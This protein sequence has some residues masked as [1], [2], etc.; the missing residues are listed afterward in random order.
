[1]IRRIGLAACA[2]VLLAVTG[3][4]AQQVITGTVVRMDPAAG[5][6]ALDNGQMYRATPQT[7]FLV[8]NQPTNFSMISP[9]T[10]VIVQSAQPVYYQDGRYI[11]MTQ[12]APAGTVVAAPAPVANAYE[13]SGVVKYADAT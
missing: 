9:G 10:P 8:N 4:A 2:L 6:V 11:V 7:V 13:V 3:A 12:P 1:M 5:V